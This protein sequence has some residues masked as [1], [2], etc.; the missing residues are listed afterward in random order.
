MTVKTHSPKSW[1]VALLVTAVPAL[2]AVGL[3]AATLVSRDTGGDETIVAA[4]NG[5]GESVRPSAEASA[6]L[7]ATVPSAPET[8]PDAVPVPV[9][10][11][12]PPAPP[13]TEAPAPTVPVPVPTT[14]DPAARPTMTLVSRYP[15][16]VT[17]NLNG[18]IYDLAPGQ[19][20]GGLTVGPQTQGNDILYLARVDDPSCGEG[21]ADSYFRAGPG[22]YIVAIVPGR[23]ICLGGEPAPDLSA[24][25]A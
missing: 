1:T 17:M 2:L 4:A 3:A 12:E 22:H 8:T 21:D 19:E 7:R 25:P 9:P 14:V 13:V 6:L 15:A 20:I 10:T 23:S 24:T 16:A 5:H 11:T 18:V